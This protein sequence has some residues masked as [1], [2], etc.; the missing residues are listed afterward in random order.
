MGWEYA[1]TLD[2][3]SYE[4]AID[5]L[6]NAFQDFAD[7]YS[8]TRDSAGFALKV[9]DPKWPDAVQISIE[10]ADEKTGVVPCGEK[11]LYCLFFIGGDDAWE[12]MEC[13][14]N[15]LNKSNYPYV[16]DDL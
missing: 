4:K 15:T 7:K 16:M 11:Y 9:D 1:I 13:I 10:T 12:V 8:F 5:I 3:K 6:Y 14:K 2:N